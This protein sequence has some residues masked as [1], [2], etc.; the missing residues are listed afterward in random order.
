M[1]QFVLSMIIIIIIAF[2][3]GLKLC[4]PSSIYM[5]VCTA[6]SARNAPQVAY[7]RSKI[8]KFFCGGG[9]T[10]SPDL[11]TGGEGDTPSPH[12]THTPLGSRYQK[13]DNVVIKNDLSRRKIGELWSTNNK[14]GEVNSDPPKSTFS[15][16]YISAPRGCCRH[17]F[18]HTLDNYEGLLTHTPPGSPETGSPTIFNNKH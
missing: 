15:D 6:K 1:C 17:Q 9:T 18:F 5:L 16:G 13:P 3:N 12:P 7:L 8:E 11:S 10:P 2:K 14:G 4:K